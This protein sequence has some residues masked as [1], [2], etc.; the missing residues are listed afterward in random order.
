MRPSTSVAPGGALATF[1][2]I[3][4][5]DTFVTWREFPSFI[6]QVIVQPF[7][8]VFVFGK[9]ITD[10]GFARPGYADL[11]VPGIVALTAVLTAI[12][13]TALPLVIEFSF[14]REVEDRLLAP[15]PL[16]LVAVERIVVGA[17]RGIIAAA[18][19]VPV[20]L[21]VLGHVP[22]HVDQLHQLVFFTIAGALAG[23]AMGLTLGTVVNPNRI[24]VAFAVTLTPLIF[25]GCSQYPW[26][27]LAQLRWF[28]VVTLFNPL[29][30]ASEGTRASLLPQSPHMPTWIAALVL[31]AAIVVFSVLG[32]R[33]FDR[34]AID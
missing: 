6:V 10:L 5:R 3:M 22:F 4:W 16:A 9:V 18:V 1:V 24:T 17:L 34:R 28:Q 7:F 14:T 12:Q 19:I 8:L 25:T 20:S 15:I 29:T 30:Y 23:G 11:L 33:G 21:I 13:S 27:S 32:I 2:Q 26:P 31:V